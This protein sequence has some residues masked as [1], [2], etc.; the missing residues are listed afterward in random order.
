MKK[1]SNEHN[2]EQNSKKYT[3][4]TAQDPSQANF[5]EDNSKYSPMNKNVNNPSNLYGVTNN[6]DDDD[7]DEYENVSNLLRED[8]KPSGLKNV[9]NT[10]WFNSIIQAFFHLPYFRRL[11]LSFQI[12]QNELNKLDE[13]VIFAVLTV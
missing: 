12:D 7:E 6:L 9:G 11:I 2:Q 4:Q 13:N 8:G 1:Y 3:R 5:N 10:C